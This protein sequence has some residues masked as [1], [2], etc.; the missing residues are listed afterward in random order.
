MALLTIAIAILGYLAAWAYRYLDRNR[1][2]SLLEA[3]V[4]LLKG[5]VSCYCVI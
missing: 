1:Y 5:K 4:D 2:T 3:P